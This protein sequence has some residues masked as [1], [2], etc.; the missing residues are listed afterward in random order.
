MIPLEQLKNYQGRALGIAIYGNGGLKKTLAARMLP[1]PILELDFEGGSG[2]LAPW[3]RRIRAWDGKW[4]EYSQEERVALFDMVSAENKIEALI[5]PGPLV[6]I[7]SFQTMTSSQEGKVSP[8]YD[9]LHSLIANL[10]REYNSVVLDPLVEFSQV[11]QSQS[12]VK[13][14]VGVHEP[15]HVK[16]WQ[17]A[18]ERAAILLRQ[19][20]EYRDKGV[21]VYM[22][23]SEFVDKDYGTDPR[24]SWQK[25]DPYAIK[26]TLNVPGQ[27]VTKLNHMIDLQFHVRLMGG[28]VVWVTQE[29][30]ARSGSFN[31]E[32]KDRTGRIP[33]RYVQPNVR[34]VL[35]WVYGSIAAQAIYEKK[36][37]ASAGE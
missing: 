4:V 24:E 5:R 20:R 35:K 33:E 30:P 8:A 27:L 29:E 16:L 10:P 1:S 22:T 31:W 6:D 15:M 11:T 37:V 21:F 19:L 26:G 3:T 9:E 36:E 13:S 32:A 34:Q 18:Q 23:S 17:G 7:V 28:K 2:C 25:E 12:K 14:G